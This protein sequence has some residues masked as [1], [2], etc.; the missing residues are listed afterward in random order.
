MAEKRFKELLMQ[1]FKGK[2]L[3]SRITH[4]MVQGHRAKSKSETSSCFVQS[5]ITLQ[6]VL[7]VNKQLSGSV[8]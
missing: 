8:G 2:E 5:P 4:V 3:I 6:H 7:N 1:S